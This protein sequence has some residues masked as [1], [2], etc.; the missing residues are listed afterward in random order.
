MAEGINK[1][2]AFAFILVGASSWITINGLYGELSLMVDDLPEQWEISAHVA[3]IIQL[4][5]YANSK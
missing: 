4:L 1:F 3:M 2:A 5:L